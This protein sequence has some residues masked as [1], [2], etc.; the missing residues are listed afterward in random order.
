MHSNG[1]QRENGQQ[2][3]KHGSKSRPYFWKHGAVSVLPQASHPEIPE[4]CF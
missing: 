4:E 1:V 3:L 2:T